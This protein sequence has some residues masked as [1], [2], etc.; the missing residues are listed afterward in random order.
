MQLILKESL[1]YLLSLMLIHLLLKQKLQLALMLQG[2]RP[3]EHIK[4][5]QDLLYLYLVMAGVLV[6]GEHLLGTLQDLVL[7][8]DKV[9]YWNL[10]NGL[11]TTGVK[12]P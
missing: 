6:Y 1:K 4:L 3:T 7:Q 10:L 12:M 2:P 5:I 9:C 11:W 8:V